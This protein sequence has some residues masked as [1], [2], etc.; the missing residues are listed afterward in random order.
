MKALA[1]A[2]A[3]FFNVDLYFNPFSKTLTL[4][5]KNH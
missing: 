1:M 5:N 2:S 4:G 3:F